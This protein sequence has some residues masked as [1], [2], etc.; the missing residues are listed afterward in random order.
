MSKD[1]FQKLLN[2]IIDFLGEVSNF[3]AFFS[4]FA[5]QNQTEKKYERMRKVC[6]TVHDRT[7]QTHTETQR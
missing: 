3:V 1:S 7:I 2:I 6:E 4:P 5:Y